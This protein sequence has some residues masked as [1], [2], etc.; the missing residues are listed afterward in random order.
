MTSRLLLVSIK[1]KLVKLINIY[2]PNGN[3]EVVFYYDDSNW[4]TARFVSRSSFYITMFLACFLF[5]RD[6]KVYLVK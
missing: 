4:A 6:R 5:Y 2:V 3:H 1:K